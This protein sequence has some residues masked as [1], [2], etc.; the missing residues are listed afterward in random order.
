[1][2]QK[3]WCSAD[4][5][6]VWGPCPA[7]GEDRGDEPPPSREWRSRPVCGIQRPNLSRRTSWDKL[8]GWTLNICIVPY[9]THFCQFVHCLKPVVDWLR[10]QSCELL[11]I[12]NFQTA[13]GR[14]LA[15]CGGMKTEIISCR[16][17][18]SCI[19]RWPVVIVTVPRL[20]KD[21]AVR[22]TFSVDLTTDIVQVNTFN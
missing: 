13:A 14:N 7:T 4:Y 21:R 8:L 12:E 3:R 6:S 20:N 16:I 1:M 19:S 15:D 9:C 2:R 22:Q 18:F 11:V 17:I 5:P 10:K